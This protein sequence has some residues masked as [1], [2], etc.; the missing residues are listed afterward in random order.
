MGDASAPAPIVIRRV[1]KV[2]GGGHH[3]GAWK[4]A[5]ADFATAMMAF[6]LLMWLVAATT[7]EQRG[8]IAEYFNNPS[9]APGKASAPSPGMAGPGGASTSMIK[10]GAMTDAPRPMPKV[11]DPQALK[12]LARE[13]EK[14]RL[15][16]LMEQLREAIGKSQALEPFKDQLLLDI[17]PDGLRIQIV[18]KLARPMFD[19][20]SASLKDYTVAILAEVGAFVDSVPNRISISGHTDTTAYGHDARYTNWELSTDRANAARRALVGGGLHEEKVA[21]VVGLSST[22][23]FDRDHPQAPINR[24]ISI[25]VMNRDADATSVTER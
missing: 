24:R 10:L 20:G 11:V 13:E 1:R 9:M 22:V 21:L 8:A 2:V 6:F 12:A 17:T 4:V 5:F 19:V 23:Q 16:S 15:E 14:R 18:D 25:V 3:G 7:K